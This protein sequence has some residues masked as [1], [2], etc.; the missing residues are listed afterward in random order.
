MWTTPVQL[1]NMALYLKTG[2]LRKLVLQ[3]IQVTGGKVYY[4]TTVRA[5]KVMVVF[6]SPPHDIVAL[7]AAGMHLTDKPKFSEYFQGTVYGNQAYVDMAFL[8]LFMYCNGGKIL[9]TASN[10][11]QH[12]T[13]L[14][15]ELIP[16]LLQICRY[17]FTC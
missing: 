16:M 7:P 3:F 8:C 11:F 1:Q 5:D 15:C 4:H 13:P 6:D 2:L 17:L 9:S 12:C 14:R 10:N